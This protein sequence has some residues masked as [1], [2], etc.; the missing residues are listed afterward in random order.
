MRKSERIDRA[1]RLV[2]IACR[3]ADMA[4]DALRKLEAQGLFN[5]HEGTL[6]KKFQSMTTFYFGLLNALNEEKGL[7]ALKETQ[8]PK[9]KAELHA[10]TV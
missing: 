9:P 3:A 8:P 4:R 1:V 5:A 2:S 6:P 10:S 7:L